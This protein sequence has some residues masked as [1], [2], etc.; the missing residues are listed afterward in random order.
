MTYFL[1]KTLIGAAAVSALAIGAST[2]MAD[3][4]SVNVTVN[5]GKPAPTLVCNIYNQC[6]YVYPQQ[7]RQPTSV[8]TD[9]TYYHRHTVERYSDDD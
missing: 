6:W 8:E 1:K 9:E 7:Q 5:T 2:A 3:S 4:F